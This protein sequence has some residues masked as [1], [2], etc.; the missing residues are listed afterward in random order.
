[1]GNLQTLELGNNKIQK[2]NAKTLI[3]LKKLNFLDLWTNE[4]SIIDDN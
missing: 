3:G 4:I 1:M 2:I